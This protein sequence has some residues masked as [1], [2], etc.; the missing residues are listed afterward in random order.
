MGSLAASIE[1]VRVTNPQLRTRQGGLLTCSTTASHATYRSYHP[2][3]EQ[4]KQLVD[5]G[6]FI[7]GNESTYLVVDVRD[8]RL[9]VEHEHIWSRFATTLAASRQCAT[10]GSHRLHIHCE[11]GV[12]ICSP[13]LV[14]R[15]SGHNRSAISQSTR[16]L[17]ELHVAMQ[18]VDL[19]PCKIAVEMRI[20]LFMQDPTIWL[21]SE[22]VAG[23]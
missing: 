5:T 1:H 22:V 19:V 8:P 14:T 21:S 2:D 18:L 12:G 6:F 9:V 23:I 17:P 3:A 13:H 10:L 16:T 7:Q 15:F 4:V 20:Y 11:A